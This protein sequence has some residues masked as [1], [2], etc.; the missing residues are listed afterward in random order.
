ME[1]ISF[2]EQGGEY[3]KVKVE[4]GLLNGIP[5][6]HI[7]GLPD[8][9]IRESLVR[10]KSAL[11]HQ[12]FSLPKGQK[13]LVN[14]RPTHIKKTG[15][16]LELAIA[17][18]ILLETEQIQL[19]KTDNLFAY[20]QLGLKGEV[21]FLNEV[22]WL[23]LPEGQRIWT[24]LPE[25]L[26][27]SDLNVVGQLSDFHE[28]WKSI[29]KA[30][31]NELNRP[32]LSDFKFNKEQAKLLALLAH[33]GHHSLLAGPAGSG[34]STLA[35]ALHSLLIDPNEKEA[36]EIRQ[37]NH[38]FKKPIESWRPIQA[39]HHSATA[40]GI[41]GGGNPLEPG[42]VTRA[43]HGVLMM[44]EFLEFSDR[45]REGLREPIELSEIQI[46]RMGQSRILPAKFQLVATTNLC[47]CGE[48]VPK[49]IQ[50]FC[51]F[52]RQKCQAYLERLSGPLVDRFDVF[53]FSENWL[54]SQEVETSAIYKKVLKATEFM[55]TKRN[56]RKK[57]CQLSWQELMQ[58]VDEMT[59]I[60][61]LP[62]AGRS[63][64]RHI[65][66]LRVARSL[67]DFDACLKIQ[68]EHIRQALEF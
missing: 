17:L 43:H 24:G 13:V 28:N 25:D 2:A 12:G 64:R 63:R 14:L 11:R 53:C 27:D 39:P 48:F 49:K 35:Y 22:N 50:P 7:M 40:Q 61:Y 62:T 60:D 54:E 23:P 56:Q 57:N 52:S 15:R 16:G 41:L 4:V 58:E 44:D 66:I 30:F 68:K 34:K 38:Y 47:P 32:Q 10:V 9:A 20:G 3:T 31:H 37:W 19:Q 5:D 1:V 29:N 51:R 59:L 33:G 46:S 36:K 21:H 67:A 65:S 18:A 45:I 6:I 26:V 42:E 8:Q 55:K